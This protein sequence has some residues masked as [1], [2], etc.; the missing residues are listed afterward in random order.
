MF[1]NNCGLDPTR[2][3]YWTNFYKEAYLTREVRVYVE[4]LT[5]YDIKKIKAELKRKNV[6][7]D[8]L[9]SVDRDTEVGPNAIKRYK[10]PELPEHN[11][12]NENDVN[13]YVL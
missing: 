8:D 10:Q 13:M 3:A 2:Y 9:K 11:Q 7:S 1:L 6:P 5:D 4:R 12:E